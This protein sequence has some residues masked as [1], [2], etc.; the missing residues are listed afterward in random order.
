MSRIHS[1]DI[2]AVRDGNHLPRLIFGLLFEAV[3]PNGG[4]EV[5][6]AKEHF[7]PDDP[8][9]Q[10]RRDSFV[11]SEGEAVRYRIVCCEESRGGLSEV[12]D[13]ARGMGVGFG[14]EALRSAAQARGVNVQWID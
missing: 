13:V 14:P 8:R 4:A 11:I 6:R 10:N 7:T 12:I 3:E 2:G 1:L 5:R 9:F